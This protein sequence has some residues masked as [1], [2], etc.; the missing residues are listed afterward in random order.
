MRPKHK[1]PKIAVTSPI[2]HLL[3]CEPALLPGESKDMYQ[4]G[5]E[6]AIKELE[7]ETPL[8]VYLAEKIFDCLWWIR[9][10]EVQKRATLVRAMSERLRPTPSAQDVSPNQA[11]LM[12]ALWNNNWD[13]AFLETCLDRQNL[14]AEMLVQDAMHNRRGYLQQIEE[15]IALKTKTLSSL[16]GVYDTLVN[17]KVQAERLRLQNELLR[18]DLEA[19]DVPALTVEGAEHEQPSEAPG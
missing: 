12:Q 11:I 4:A 13:N 15:N 10:Y 2:S 1:H 9:R 19:I 8:Q 17:R 7:A 16:Q 14:S 5:L 3:G 6:A 18:R